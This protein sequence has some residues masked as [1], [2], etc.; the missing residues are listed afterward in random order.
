[1]ASERTHVASGHLGAQLPPAA[2]RVAALEEDSESP[3]R[4]DA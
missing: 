1:M 3:F 4:G 2:Q